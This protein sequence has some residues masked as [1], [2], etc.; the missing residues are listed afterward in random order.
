VVEG[1]GFAIGERAFGHPG[2]GGSIAFADPQL[3]LSFAYITNRMNG[4]PTLDS[5]AQSLIDVVYQTLGLSDRERGY[6]C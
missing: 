4:L 3:G 2:M 5:R 6:W 1:R